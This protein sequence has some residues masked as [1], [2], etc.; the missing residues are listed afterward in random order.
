MAG[1]HADALQRRASAKAMTIA[2]CRLLASVPS[3][4]RGKYLATMTHCAHLVDVMPDG[5]TRAQGYCKH[6]HCI[7]CNRI[8]TAQLWNQYRD[9]LAAWPDKH[10]VTLSRPN[11]PAHVL[12]REIKD[13]GQWWSR[14]NTK[15]RQRIRRDPDA[16]RPSG[17]RKLEVTYNPARN[18]YHPHYHVIINCR[19][20][21]KALYNDWL[22]DHTA[23]RRVAQDMRKADDG[24]ALELFKY[25]SKLVAGGKGGVTFHAKAINEI[26]CALRGSQIVKP[27]GDTK[28]AQTEEAPDLMASV[29]RV[30]YARWKHGAWYEEHEEERPTE[31][32]LS[33][34]GSILTSS[35]HYVTGRPLNQPVIAPLL[36][37]DVEATLWD[38]REAK[39]NR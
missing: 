35:T 27:F 13:L 34:Y 33:Q 14:W 30:A 4:L 11:V 9:Q 39:G 28:A 17:I 5:S 38:D 10:F 37:S 8:R 18:D 15:Y 1:T 20:A 32:Y 3:P 22:S 21:A 29:E 25:F 31:E 23:A 7:V 24:T 16:L 36:L 6:R 26:L 12:A 2:I 19:H